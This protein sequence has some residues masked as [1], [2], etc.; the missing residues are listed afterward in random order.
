MLAQEPITHDNWPAV[1]FPA[2]QRRHCVLTFVVFKRDTGSTLT[3]QEPTTTEVAIQVKIEKLQDEPMKR[4][5]WDNCFRLIPKV[6]TYRHLYFDTTKQ[7]ASAA[8]LAV[9]QPAN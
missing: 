5:H 4:Q 3:A 7:G 8:Q 1:T 2:M 6:S 9:F